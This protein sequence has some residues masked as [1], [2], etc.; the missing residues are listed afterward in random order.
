M[1]ILTVL[2]LCLCVSTAQADLVDDADA[3]Y[4]K[5]DY[6]TAFR[7]LTQLAEQGDA[8][9]QHNLG[10]MYDNGQGTP[11]DYA[12]ALKWTRLAAEQGNAS[13][14]YNLGFMHRNGHGTPQNYAEAMKW[15][16]LAAEQGNVSALL[17]LGF[18]YNGGL[19]VLQDYVET[20][21]WFNLAA[22][23]QTNEEK[24]KLAIK[25][26]DIIAKLMTPAQV[27]EA[28]KLAKQWDKAHPR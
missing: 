20:H 1:K 4:Q 6:A 22:S 8:F 28:Q 25:N 27:A 24:R 26:R 10:I 12:E 9:A 19:G 16:R 5:G 18:M 23:R 3:A 7:L 15:Y 17:N 13:A 11:Q 14:Q 21:K 2:A